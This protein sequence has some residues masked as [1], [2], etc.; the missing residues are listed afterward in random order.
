MNKLTKRALSMLLALVLCLSLLPVVGAP[1]AAATVE[2][3]T[4]DG[5]SLKNKNPNGTDQTVDVILNWGER[6]TTATFL[7]ANAVSFYADNNVSYVT[8]SDLAGDQDQNAVNESELYAALQSLLTD[9]H[10]LWTDYDDTRYL[11]QYTDCQY[12]DINHLTCFYSGALIGPEWDAGKTWNR[13]HTWPKSKS[14]DKD[15]ASYHDKNDLMMLRPTSSAANSSRNNAAYGESDGYFDPNGKATF[16]DVRG[17]VARIM[18]YQYIRWELPN[19][20]MWGTDGVIESAEVLLDWMEADPVDTWEMGRNDSVESITGTRNVFVDY[21]EL[22]FVLLDAEIPS[23]MTT[24]SGEAMD[25]G[26]TITAVPNNPAYGTVSVSGNNINAFPAVGYEVSGYDVVA[27]A[28]NITRNGNVFTVDAPSDCKIMISFSAKGAA[29]V[30]YSQNGVAAAT[31]NAY[32]GDMITLPD[33]TGT[34]PEGHAFLGWV[35]KTVSKTETAPAYMSAGSK[36]TV[37]GNVTLYALYSYFDPN[38]IPSAGG[39]YE[40]YAGTMTEG[41]YMLVSDGGAM[42][43]EISGGRFAYSD[44]TVTDD[45]IADPD[46]SL[47]WTVAADGNY[48]TFYNKAQSKYAA[49]NGTA[50]KGDLVSS[51]NDYARWDYTG[52]YD[53]ENVG[54][55]A[56]NVNYT[57][58]RNTSYGFALYKSTTGTAVELYRLTNGATFYNTTAEVVARPV[59]SVLYSQNGSVAAASSAYEGDAVVLVDHAGAVPEGC[60]FLGWVESSVDATTAKPEAIL[61]AGSKYRPSASTTLYALYTWADVSQGGDGVYKLHT[62]AL[63]EGNYLITYSAEAMKAE[64]S[65]NRFCYTN[66]TV[67]DNQITDPDAALVWKLAKSGDYWTIYNASTGMYAAS[68]GTKNQGQLLTSGTDNKSLWTVSGTAT[69]EFVNK[70]NAEKSINSNLRKNGNHGFACYSTSTGGALTLYKFEASGTLFGTATATGGGAVTAPEATLNGGTAISLQQAVDYATSGSVIKLEKDVTAEITLPD[71]VTLDLAGYTF[72]GGIIGGII[73]D[74]TDGEGCI[75]NANA[76]ADSAVQ[77][78]EMLLKGSDGWHVYTFEMAAAE[79]ESVQATAD[80]VY[81]WF[82]VSFN[83]PDAY[84]AIATGNSGFTV[85]AVFTW[86]GGQETPAELGSNLLIAEWARDMQISTDYSFYVKVVG[87]NAAAESGDLIVR[88]TISAADETLGCCTLDDMKYTV[89]IN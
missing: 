88:P 23:D 21:P 27:G 10:G 39:V 33:Y 81:F 85:G 74:S 45:K 37:S 35:E 48:W 24:P 15:V 58:R 17:D 80:A 22:A 84:K 29:T 13:E 78:G 73:T 69:Y 1:A 77:D 7:S 5:I 65:N 6:G 40:K 4:A 76:P 70:A 12:S 20:K 8:L 32:V 87:L 44:V 66:I 61:Q 42:K 47:V 50:N 83:N 49:G 54:N 62:G 89:T 64:T 9:T 68:T 3:V 34:V 2:Y 57:L 28:A 41:S 75:V 19:S 46:A 30:T 72:T 63:V 18:L 52:T 26:Y 56:A 16:T 38:A 51:V 14:L 82:D 59:F 25:L 43:A 55:K 36:Y 67:E 86:N 31:A 60:A 79:K 11:Y 71:N 53:I